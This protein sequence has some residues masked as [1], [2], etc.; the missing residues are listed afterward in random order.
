MTSVQMGL[1]LMER[2][3]LLPSAEPESKGGF[4][5][6]TVTVVGVTPG[7]SLSVLYCHIPCLPP[8][9]RLS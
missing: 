9:G 3:Y 6:R 2:G 1:G 7:L 5:S 8:N 4:Y